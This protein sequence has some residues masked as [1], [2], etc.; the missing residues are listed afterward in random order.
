MVATKQITVEEFEAM[1]LEGR[2]ELIDGELVEMSPSANRSGWIS[3]RLFPRLEQFVDTH[4]LGW[5]FPPETGC[6]LFSDRAIVRS[7]DAAFVRRDRMPELSDHFVPVA[8][9]LAAEVLSPSD[10]M[11]EALS[12]VA[13]YLEAGVHLVWLVEPVERT[14]MVFRPVGSP[15]TLSQGD[16]LD[17]GDV[18]PGFRIPLNDIFG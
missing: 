16:A 6:I 12:K 5:A 9:D 10:R 8:P 14:V 17:G 4:D 2:W 7:P 13:M 18:L 1:P 15:K 11:A 3:G